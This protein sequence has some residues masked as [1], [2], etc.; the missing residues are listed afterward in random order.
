MSFTTPVFFLFLP[1]VLLIY[2][3][4]P[5][6]YRWIHLLASSCFFYAFYDFRLLSLIF[7]TTFVSYLGAIH[8]EQ[9]QTK[10]GR[11]KALLGVMTTCL[12]ILFGFKYLN[13]AANGLFSLL[14]LWGMDIS[15]RRIPVL[16][17][18][19]ISFYVFQTISY[20]LDVYHGAIPAERHLGHYGLFVIFF[21]QLTAGP[22]ER[23]GALLPQL[24]RPPAFS[25][26]YL[27]EGCSLLL[28]GYA[29]KIL[30]ADYLAGYVDIAYGN[31]PH[32]GGAALLT[33]TVL[34]AIQIYCDFSGY[35]DIASGCAKCM[36]IRLSDNFRRPYAAGSIREFWQRWHISLTHWF[37]DYLYI[38]LGGSRKGTFRHCINIMITFLAS[39]LWHGA[40]WTFIFWG[41]LHGLYL[42]AETLCF[43]RK[44][45]PAASSETLRETSLSGMCM[46][47]ARR[48]FVF[49]MVCFAWI[50]F[51]AASLEDA[52]YVIG[53]IFTHWQPEN[54][55]PA[56]GLTQSKVLLLVLLLFLVPLLDRLP[57][58][59][60]TEQPLTHAH[61]QCRT[62]LLYFLMITA[63]FLCRS[64][65]LNG[66]GDKAFIYFQF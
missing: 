58:Y 41:G 22:I 39:G 45:L 21:P 15:F 33:A 59:R 27:A 3:L 18:M 62:A 42:I 51:R 48:A 2:W 13:F 23:P 14:R 52:F 29:K 9:A 30:I 25:M 4:L 16:L 20:T 61:A 56:L 7:V 31:I 28:R 47:L 35:S 26:E 43:R 54:L 49:F 50:F 66:S 46:A 1:V 64:L 8:M 34:F 6:K 53:K 11:K 10:K 17:P 19:G 63:I 40:D 5:G 57:V 24:K 32:A 60:R 12:G 36:G 55:F 65:V 37:T 44:S 38:P